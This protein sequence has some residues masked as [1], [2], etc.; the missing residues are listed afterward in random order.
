MLSAAQRQRK[1]A[2]RVK[3]RKEKVRIEKSRP[4]RPSE[5]DGPED[6][7]LIIDK[8]EELFGQGDLDGFYTTEQINE[9]DAIVD[10]YTPEQREAAI[11]L[12][13]ALTWETF[14][15]LYNGEANHAELRQR[16]RQEQG[17]GLRPVP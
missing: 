7:L 9:V 8:R 6:S 4:I 3:A 10:G 15:Q 14:E 17:R 12:A 1:M 13:K 5:R 16:E 11:E 2:K